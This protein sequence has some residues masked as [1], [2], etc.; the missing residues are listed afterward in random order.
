LKNDFDK[1]AEIYDRI[2]TDLDNDIDFY[3]KLASKSK[4]KV[5]EIGCGTGRVTIPIAQANIKIVGIDISKNM[6]N[7]LNRKI[8]DTHFDISCYQM[9]MRNININ[10]KFDLV[11]I[12]FNGFQSMLTVSDQYKCLSSIRE[13]MSSNGTLALDMFTPSLDMF[14][15]NEKIWYVVKEIINKNG[16]PNMM[17]K[18]SSKYELTN[19]IIYT[20]LMIE[21]IL[22]NKITKTIYNNFSLRYNNRHESEYL[23]KNSGFKISNLYGDFKSNPFSAN[24]E[25]MIW[26]LKK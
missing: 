14:D 12:P 7:I 2:Y 1:W 8:K 9:D 10:E 22:K 17:V 23:F 11:I 16:I 13:H 21:E 26:L 3:T 24:S 6:I 15:Q 19:Q 20:T 18:H 25:K 5:L 4:G